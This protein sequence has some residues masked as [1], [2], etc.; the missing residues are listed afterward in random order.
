M[1][2]Y[3]P[4]PDEEFLGRQLAQD[5]QVMAFL[6]LEAYVE[7]LNDQI[8][9]SYDNENGRYGELDL[10]EVIT[11]AESHLDT[12]DRWGGDY[13]VKGGVFEGQGT[14]PTFWDKLAILK[15][16]EIPQEKRSN[17]FS[18]SC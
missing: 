5:P 2:P 14:D 17:F 13:I 1:R 11:T 8:R 7:N 10:A 6:W 18:C 4:C 16:I 9:S 3:Q 12:K 15:G